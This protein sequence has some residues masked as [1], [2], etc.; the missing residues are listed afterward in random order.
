[1]KWREYMIWRRNNTKRGWR[2]MKIREREKRYSEKGV[3]RFGSLTHGARGLEDPD[4]T[5]SPPY[6]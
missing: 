1:M 2:K 3:A 5:S 6:L 4:Y